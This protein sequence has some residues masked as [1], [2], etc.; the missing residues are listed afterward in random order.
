M[1]AGGRGLALGAPLPARVGELPD[2]LLFLGIHADHR[3]PGALMVLDL[4]ADVPELRVPVRVPPALDGLGVALQL[5]PAARS[6]SPTVSAETLWPWRV[7]S[8]AR[9]RVDFAVHRSG[10][11]GSPRSCGSTRASSAGR[12]PGSRS[13]ARLRPSPG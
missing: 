11:I 2:K 7:S 6:R 8:S 10:D 12:S 3:V 5:N 4:L 13:A 9:L 1:R